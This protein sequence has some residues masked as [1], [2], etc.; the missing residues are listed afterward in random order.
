MKVWNKQVRMQLVDITLSGCLNCW[1][2]AHFSDPYSVIVKFGQVIS[3]CELPFFFPIFPFD[4]PLKR[5]IRKPKVFWCFQGG[6]RVNIW[7]GKV[8]LVFW[9]KLFVHKYMWFF[10][11]LCYHWYNLENGKNIHGRV[12]LLLKLQASAFNFTKSNT[13]PWMFFYVF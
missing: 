6:S 12:L 13:L 2:R 5:Y 3:C 4:P 10:A 1:L 8:T 11:R 7:K 9:M